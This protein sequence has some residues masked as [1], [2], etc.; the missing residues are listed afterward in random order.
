MITSNLKL[1][2]KQKGKTLRQLSADALVSENTILKARSSLSI[3]DCNL[4]SLA[5]I[6]E[7]LDCSVKDLFEHEKN[8]KSLKAHKHEKP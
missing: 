3:I 4:R 1:L 2:M 8:K 7:A 5:R 6:A